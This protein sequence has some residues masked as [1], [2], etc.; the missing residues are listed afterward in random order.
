MIRKYLIR[1]VVL[2]MFVSTFS[3]S[4]HNT[5]AFAEDEITSFESITDEELLNG[6]EEAGYDREKVI[7]DANNVTT[8]FQPITIDD[9]SPIN[10]MAT[11]KKGVTKVVKTSKYLDLYLSEFAQKV[12]L[13]IGSTGAL[14]L[15]ALIPGVGW[16]LAVP[17]LSA[18]SGLI[19]SE[20][21][22]YGKIYRFSLV[23]GPT[24]LDL[25][26]IRYQY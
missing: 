24:N 6:L 12:I 15:L 16:A 26:S 2:L 21:L 1:F 3:L 19:I 7:L 11:P 25:M 14:S 18:L 22:K 13:T 10:L 9:P 8:T 20:K 23:N 4:L 17:M 5:K